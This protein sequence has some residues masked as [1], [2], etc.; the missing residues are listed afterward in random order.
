MHRFEDLSTHYARII[1]LVKGLKRKLP[2]R[3]PSGLSH[4]VNIRIHLHRYHSDDL[5]RRFL[6]SSATIIAG[7]NYTASQDRSD[8]PE[9]G[10]LRVLRHSYVRKGEKHRHRHRNISLRDISQYPQMRFA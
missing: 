5:H 9:A 4:H 2:R 1:P 7:L 3:A 10:V 8:H 6:P